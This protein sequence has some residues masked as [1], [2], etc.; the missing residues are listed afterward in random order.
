MAAQPLVMDSYDDPIRT[1]KTN[2]LGV[3]NV[4]DAIKK[5]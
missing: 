2:T 5:N 3:L 1:F 4:L